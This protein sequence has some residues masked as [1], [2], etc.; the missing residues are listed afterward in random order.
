MYSCVLFPH[1]R[2]SRIECSWEMAKGIQSVSLRLPCPHRSLE[3]Y[4]GLCW[5]M[6]VVPC[7]FAGKGKQHL[8]PCCLQLYT[9][10]FPD[11]CF[12]NYQTVLIS[13]EANFMLNYLKLRQCKP[14]S[15]EWPFLGWLVSS[16]ITTILCGKFGFLPISDH[17]PI[18]GR[19]QPGY[20]I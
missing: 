6:Q 16:K 20:F 2:E 19:T 18:T 8:S 10:N 5:E 15:Q 3:T 17:F 9:E 4:W 1:F 13:G 11:Y 7:R 14:Q 12:N